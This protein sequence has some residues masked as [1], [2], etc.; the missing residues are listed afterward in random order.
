MVRSKLYIGF[1][2]RFDFRN[3]YGLYLGLV[4]LRRLMQTSLE[5]HVR[6]VNPLTYV[7]YLNE[8]KEME[9]HNLILDT[10]TDNVHIILKTI[11]KL[12]MNEYKYHYFITSFDIEK[13]DLEDFKYNF[14]NIT[15]FCLVDV[16]DVRTISA[17]IYDSVHIFVI[18]LQSLQQSHFLRVA[19]VSCESPQ[20]WKGGLS[21][22]NYIN[23]LQCTF[24]IQLQFSLQYFLRITHNLQQRQIRQQLDYK[25]VCN[26]QQYATTNYNK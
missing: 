10:K 14:A 4:Q 8:M 19:N 6:Y 18:G 16:N 20:T 7:Q 24:T 22:I 13:F 12:Q 1:Y 17:L 15:S 21:L 2:I 11:L 23:S 26:V 9:M 5:V 3:F 25:D